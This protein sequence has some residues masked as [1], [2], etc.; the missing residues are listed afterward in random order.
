M[1]EID[2]IRSHAGS[3]LKCDYGWN[4]VIPGESNAEWMEFEQVAADSLTAGECAECVAARLAAFIFERVG[5]RYFRPR[6]DG[7]PNRRSAETAL[8]YVLKYSNKA[9]AND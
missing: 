2:K 7:K 5:M 9:A 3:I 8:A 6:I 1:S 4:G